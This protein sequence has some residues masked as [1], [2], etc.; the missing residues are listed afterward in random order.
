MIGHLAARLARALVSRSL[1]SRSLVTLPLM[2]LPLM[3]LPLAL[4]PAMMLALAPVTAHAQALDLSRGGPIAIT[5]EDGIE[6]RQVEQQVIARGNA[7]AVRENVT[8]TADRLIAWYRKKGTTGAPP[9][10]TSAGTPAGVK[11]PSGVD[12][13]SSGNEVYRFQAEGNVLIFTETDQAYGDKATYDIDQAVM[14]MT[15]RDLKLITQNEVLTA[16][17]S[18][19]YWAQKRMAVARGNAVVVT[20]D[21]KRLAAD[22]LVAYTSEAPPPS[23]ATSGVGPAATPKPAGGRPT[24]PSAAQSGKL[25]KMEAFGN[26]SIRTPTD[27]VTGDRGVYVPDIGIARLGGQVR[28]TRGETQL[29]GSGADVN[30][31]TGVARLTSDRGTRVQGLVVPGDQSSQ[32][33]PL[34]APPAARPGPKR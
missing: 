29:N 20:N 2:S 5:A 11:P 21:A 30:M 23:G 4:V 19:E 31:K 26:V 18:L 33:L 16:R 34:D 14:V 10:G 7:R 15:G 1:M 25:E 22:T 6:W 3:S 27:F 8:V 24:E 13:D 9:A 12:A 17:D 32:G 28:I